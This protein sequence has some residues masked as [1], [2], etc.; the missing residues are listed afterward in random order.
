MTLDID[1][2]VALT[3]ALRRIGGLDGEMWDDIGPHLTCDEA[4]AFAALLLAIGESETMWRMLAAHASADEEGDH[5]Y[6]Y[7]GERGTT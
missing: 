7:M 3:D 2:P 6:G 4:E 5:H 1:N